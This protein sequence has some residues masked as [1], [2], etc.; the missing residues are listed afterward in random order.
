[1]TFHLSEYSVDPHVEDARRVLKQ[2][3]SGLALFNNPQSFRPEPAVILASLLLACAGC[4]LAWDSSRKKVN[5]SD[6]FGCVE[7]FDVVMYWYSRP[8]FSQEIAA[9]FVYLAHGDNLQ[10]VTPDP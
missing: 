2:E 10:V 6:P 8:C 3:P 5:C 4:R 1:L 7:R 9:P